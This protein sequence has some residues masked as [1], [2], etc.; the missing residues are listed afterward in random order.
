M[1]GFI[2]LD[3]LPRISE[4]IEALARW[5]RVG[6][7]VQKGAVAVGL[8]NAPRTLMHLFTGEN[9]GKHITHQTTACTKPRR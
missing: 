2:I 5:Q 6:K 8:E 4:A 9:L 1:E 7:L 3:Y